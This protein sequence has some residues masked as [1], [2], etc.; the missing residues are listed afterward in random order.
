[1]FFVCLLVFVALVLV[2]DVPIDIESCFVVCHNMLPGPA[3]GT[4]GAGG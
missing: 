4:S 3:R 2:I 1:V